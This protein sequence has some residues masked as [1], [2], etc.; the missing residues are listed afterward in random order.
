MKTMLRIVRFYLLACGCVGLAAGCDS[1]PKL[2]PLVP[3]SGKV[4]IGGQPATGGNVTLVPAAPGTLPQGVIATGSIDSSGNYQISSGGKT[5][6]PVGQYKV[7]VSPSMVPGSGGSMS[8]TK[9]VFKK[10]SAKNT[11]LNIDVKEN[12]GPYDLKLDK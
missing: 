8:D 6:A 2:P 9:E 4:T 12:G 10:Y 11:P 1:G 5:G 7:T 3:V